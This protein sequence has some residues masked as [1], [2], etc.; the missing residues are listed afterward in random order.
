MKSALSEKTRIDQG[1]AYLQSYFEDL[2][3]GSAHSFLSHKK[4]TRKL[5]FLSRDAI[6]D[7][8]G[9]GTLD[10]LV[11]AKV[12]DEYRSQSFFIRSIGKASHRFPKILKSLYHGFTRRSVTFSFQETVRDHISD[13]MKQLEDAT[14]LR[15]SNLQ[16]SK[17][18]KGYGG[19]V[20]LDTSDRWAVFD[21]YVA[22]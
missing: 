19:K 21:W 8:I 5:W 10:P 7:A 15:V 20:K 18:K 2:R 4:V 14:Q 1:Y 9:S 11:V 16:T 13:I 17:T 22:M 12:Y 3:L 6:Y